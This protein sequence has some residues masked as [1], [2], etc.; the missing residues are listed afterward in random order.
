MKNPNGAQL[1][2]MWFPKLLSRVYA[3]L[4]L[5]RQPT[6]FNEIKKN[7]CIYFE[8]LQSVNNARAKV[9]TNDGWRIERA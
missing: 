8:R 2:M 3:E 6:P 4:Q 1:K 5:K 9:E 7:I